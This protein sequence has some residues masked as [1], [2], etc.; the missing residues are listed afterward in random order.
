MN[1]TNKKCLLKQL[2]SDQKRHNRARQLATFELNR[3][4][5]T[6]R[7]LRLGT[8]PSG[9]DQKWLN[10]VCDL[11]CILNKKNDSGAHDTVVG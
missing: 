10:K 9:E 3:V 8:V 2:I 5:T 1:I 4:K 11:K 6:V 7:K